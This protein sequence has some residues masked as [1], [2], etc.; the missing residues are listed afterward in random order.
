M[1]D[2]TFPR[3]KR[4]HAQM[5]APV[6]FVTPDGLVRMSAPGRGG[7]RRP[8]ALDLALGLRTLRMASRFHMGD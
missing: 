7:W 6:L 1:H 2:V 3:P 4:K 8:S 5:G